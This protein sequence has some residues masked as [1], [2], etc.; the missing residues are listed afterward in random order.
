[1]TGP[2]L[3]DNSLALKGNSSIL[4]LK[5]SLW[6]RLSS[7][8]WLSRSFIKFNKII[9]NDPSGWSLPGLWD[10]KLICLVK[11]CVSLIPHLCLS[12]ILLAV[13]CLTLPLF[14]CTV[15][16]NLYFTRPWTFLMQT[17][18]LVNKSVIYNIKD[19]WIPF[20]FFTHLSVVHADSLVQLNGTKPFFMSQL[21]LDISQ[22]ATSEL[23]VG[24]SQASQMKCCVSF[25]GW[26]VTPLLQFILIASCDDVTNTFS[27]LC[28]CVCLCVLLETSIVWEGPTEVGW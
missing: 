24:T 14:A 18:W 20:S 3:P 16:Y 1:M 9:P 11:I 15:Q 13:L 6:I 22:T 8:L 17:L 27:V 4:R 28:V 19:G 10:H 2:I 12:E 23:H 26:A 5:V 21:P 25:C 7:S